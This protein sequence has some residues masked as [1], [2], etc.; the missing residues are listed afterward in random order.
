MGKKA[1]KPVTK[2]SAKAATKPAPGV[3]TVS[4]D[5]TMVPAATVDGAVRDNDL[6]EVTSN[7][8]GKILLHALRHLDQPPP[9][10]L[11]E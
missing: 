5:D 7:L 10:L 8:P 1:K 6:D 4:S 3:W 2:K 11:Q 9:G